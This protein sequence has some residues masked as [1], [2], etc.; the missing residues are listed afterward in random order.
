[1][2]FLAK[3]TLVLPLLGG[4]ASTA[5]DQGTGTAQVGTRHPPGAVD[6]S[7]A[8]RRLTTQL[9]GRWHATTERGEVQVTYTFFSADSAMVEVFQGSSGRQTL[10]VYHLAGPRL[11]LTHYCAQKNQPRLV[12]TAADDHTLR[13]ELSDVTDLDPGES[14]MRVMVVTLH[15]DA[16]D[17]TATYVAPDGTQE[18]ET[19]HFVRSP[20][21][22]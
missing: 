8:W 12:A 10:S 20:P 7:A 14:M 2:R 16:F 18:T 1:M 21:V 22:P 11:M 9:L 13:F 5:A 17:Q 6:A 19:L 4:C 3:L 15:P